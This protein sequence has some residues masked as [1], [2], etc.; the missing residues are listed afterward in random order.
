MTDF[1]VVDAYSDDVPPLFT[2]THVVFASNGAD[3]KLYLNGTLSFTFVAHALQ[4]FGQQGLAGIIN[5][6]GS[7]NDLLDG[8]IRE[9]ASYNSELSAA[10]IQTHSA[11]F[12]VPEP[13]TF[14]MG[15]LAGIALITRRRRQLS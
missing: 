12:A 4:L 9:F 8:T 6:D 3:T 11:A 13:S 10:E 14:A 15:T 1:G 7:F 2:D 5:S